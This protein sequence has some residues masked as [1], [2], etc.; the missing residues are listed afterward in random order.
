ME[1][2]VTWKTNLR[3]NDGSISFPAT[4]TSNVCTR[5]S[6]LTRKISQKVWVWVEY[7]FSFQR[8]RGIH[9]NYA[10]SDQEK[11]PADQALCIKSTRME[12]IPPQQQTLSRWRSFKATS[13]E[14]RYRRYTLDLLE[15]I[16]YPSFPTTR[17]YCWLADW[18]RNYPKTVIVWRHS[19]LLSPQQTLR[20]R[21][22]LVTMQCFVRRKDGVS[23]P[24]LL[25]KTCTVRS[26][27]L[28][29]TFPVRLRGQR[30]LRFGYVQCFWGQWL[31]KVL[32]FCEKMTNDVNS[33]VCKK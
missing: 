22:S 18:K 21:N 29:R 2:F 1:I 19:Y 24:I 11:H 8:A 25:W 26:V 12:S 31:V 17:A 15:T 20:P 13:N 16:L 4:K 10:S 28:F 30:Q 9:D 32:H 33:Y 3:H 6:A 5:D 7:S 23:A 27:V 14:Q